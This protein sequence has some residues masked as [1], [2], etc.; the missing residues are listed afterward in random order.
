MF[1]SMQFVFYSFMIYSNVIAYST[2][3]FSVWHFIKYY[4][5]SSV[6]EL[7]ISLFVIII[8]STIKNNSLIIFV[9]E[10]IFIF[11][12]L[13]NK[14]NQKPFL[15]LFA[16]LVLFTVMSKGTIYFWETKA[17]ANYNNKLP[18]SC[19]LAYGVNYDKN[20]PGG[21]TNEFENFHH[22]N[23]YNP[24]YTDEKAKEFI[25]NSL[26]RFKERPDI[27]FKFYGQKFLFSFANP[28][29]DT[30]FSYKNLERNSFTD[31]VISGGI[32]EVL[33]NI[34]DGTSSVLSIGL[35]A[36]ILINF[37]KIN[38]NYLFL[39]VC[40]FGGFLF[41]LFWETKSIYL[42]QYYLLLMPYASKG[43]SDLLNKISH[44]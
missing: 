24:V 14:F 39:G 32:N 31:S 5:T 13:I 11:V 42:Y 16:S 40:I 35:L 29:Y 44:K 38:L 25:N 30:F 15:I 8:S 3:M 18:F 7:S 12:K 27:A 9:A 10:I 19:W 22:E 20:N 37:K 43:I 36:Y 4:K 23:G 28:E 33:F 21:Y 2:S 6:K 1:F 17:S 26:N 41:H 34:W